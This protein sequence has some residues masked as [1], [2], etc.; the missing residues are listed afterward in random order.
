MKCGKKC[1]QNQ[2]YMQTK[3]M[4]N[5]I[6]LLVKGMASGVRDMLGWILAPL[7]ECTSQN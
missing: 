2:E 7:G 3:L 6:S 5:I 1:Y 4:K